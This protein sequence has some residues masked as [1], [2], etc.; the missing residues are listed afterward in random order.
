MSRRRGNPEQRWLA[1][2]L[3][4]RVRWQ[5]IKC[6]QNHGILGLLRARLSDLRPAAGRCGVT[7]LSTGF[8]DDVS[9]A[10]PV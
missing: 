1:I 2:H 5:M 7:T 6:Y 4:L 8:S 10:V 9:T 3:S